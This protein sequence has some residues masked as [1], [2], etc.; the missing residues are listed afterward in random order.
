MEK[1]Q[2]YALVLF[3]ISGAGDKR[4]GWC[5]SNASVPISVS[6]PFSSGVGME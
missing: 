1:H 6:S 3:A 2:K 4:N 5:I